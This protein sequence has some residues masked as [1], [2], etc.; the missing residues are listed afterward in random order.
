VAL[1]LWRHVVG[2]EEG[3]PLVTSRLSL[4]YPRFVYHPYVRQLLEATTRR[5]EAAAAAAG[6]PASL[7]CLVLPSRAAADRC[8]DFLVRAV[9]ALDQDPNEQPASH[10]NAVDLPPDPPGAD[11][12]SLFSSQ[13]G[14]QA[15]RKVKVLDLGVGADP[16]L[17]AP[18]PPLS[19]NVHAVVFPRSTELAVQAKSYWQH[20][21]EVLSSRRAE[22]ALRALGHPVA[23]VTV[24]CP[25]SPPSAKCEQ[26][27]PL[28]AQHPPPMPQPKEPHGE[29]VKDLARLSGQPEGHVFLAPSGMQVRA[30]E[31][32]KKKKKKKKKKKALLML[33]L[34]CSESGRA[35]GLGGAR[36]KRARRRRRRRCALLMLLS[37]SESGRNR[38]LSGGDPPNPPC[39]RRGRT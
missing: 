2:Y 39:G 34:S 17:P 26:S 29:L 19:G 36:A 32:S 12:A 20:T 38:G 4:G 6:G 22:A 14:G 30:S 16:A 23:P 31:A 28:M 5:A 7:D 33:L 35:R 11:L 27:R 21:G 15:G 9:P 10:D 18:P 37:C 13:A 8:R 24:S 1:P 25:S 3:C